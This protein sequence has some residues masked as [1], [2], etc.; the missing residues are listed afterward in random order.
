MFK[1]VTAD[2]GVALLWLYGISTQVVMGKI[3]YLQ[4]LHLKNIFQTSK[5]RI[6]SAF[7]SMLYRSC[8]R[9]F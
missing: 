1:A 5:K 7:V 9:I 2:L 4:V 6:V 8:V 3:I